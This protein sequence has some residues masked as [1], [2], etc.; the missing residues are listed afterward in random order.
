MV[1]F[2]YEITFGS[3]FKN[4]LHLV[5]FVGFVTSC[6]RAFLSSKFSRG[7]F[8]S[9]IFFSC[10]YF[11]CFSWMFQGSKIFLVGISWVQFFF[12]W[13]FW[14]FKLFSLGYYVGPFKY[15]PSAQLTKCHQSAESSKSLKELKAGIDIIFNGKHS[16]EMRFKQIVIEL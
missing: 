9:S 15:P 10:E 6:H 12:A 11:E 2:M 16:S 13:I 5:G 3:F 14:G 1:E 8:V 4:V 7:Y